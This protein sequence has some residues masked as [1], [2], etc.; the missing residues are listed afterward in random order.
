MEVPIKAGTSAV[1]DAWCTL[2]TASLS[3]SEYTRTAPCRRFL[4]YPTSIPAAVFG[5]NP[6]NWDKSICHGSYS[7]Y[8]W[9]YRYVEFC[10]VPFSA[11]AGEQSLYRYSAHLVMR[12]W[13]QKT[14][15]S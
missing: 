6:L 2:N 15:W 4:K 5:E 7:Q 11:P 3:H 14:V 1:L 13:A 8:Y 12:R 10:A 9:G